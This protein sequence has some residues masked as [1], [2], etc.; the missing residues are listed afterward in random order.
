MN[1]VLE[2]VVGRVSIVG[3]AAGPVKADDV[4]ESI[5]TA[6]RVDS[7]Q[8][9]PVIADPGVEPDGVPSDAPAGFI[10]GDVAGVFELQGDLLVSGFESL[11]GSMDDL[12]GGA[13]REV[14]AE[15]A[16]E[17]VGDFA[18]GQ[19]GLLVEINDGGLGVGADLASSGAGGVGGLEGVSAAAGVAALL[20]FAAV[21]G[22]FSPQ[23]FVADFLLEEGVGVSFLDGAI[24]LGAEVGQRGLQ[25][26]VDF[27]FGRR[28]PMAV[29][30]VFFVGL[31]AWLFGFVLG[32]SFGEG[33]GLAL[34]GPFDGFDA[35]DEFGDAFF[36]FGNASIACGTAGATGLGRGVHA[37]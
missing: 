8:G 2:A 25:G 19:A 33:S 4:F 23:R 21:D 29:G 31:T 35:D 16:F 1:R 9:S 12:C 18:V 7:I 10:G 26:F 13:A 14:D 34:A 5:G 28:E 6:S 3:H 15:A 17:D 20:A 24:A 27:I 22:E 32:L 30:A 36:E 37:E 11:G